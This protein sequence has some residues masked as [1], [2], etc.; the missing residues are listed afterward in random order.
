MG[1]AYIENPVISTEISRYLFH[2]YPDN[3]LMEA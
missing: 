3:N 2:G 1:E